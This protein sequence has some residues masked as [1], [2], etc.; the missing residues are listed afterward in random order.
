MLRLHGCWLAIEQATQGV[1]D[2]GLAWLGDEKTSR[3][4]R[5]AGTLVTFHFVTAAWIVFRST[6]LDEAARRYATVG[7]AVSQIIT[8]PQDFLYAISLSHSSFVLVT[9]V[10]ASWMFAEWCWSMR[11]VPQ[12]FDRAPRSA[13]WLVFYAALLLVVVFGVYD[14]RP[15]IYS[16]F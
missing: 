5:T 15:F 2:R 9:T 8:A 4:R 16:G 1:R 3:I 12:A 6:S 10:I 13:R 7:S 14:Q 11:F